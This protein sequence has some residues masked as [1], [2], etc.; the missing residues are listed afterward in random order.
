MQSVTSQNVEL[1]DA[2][3]AL[4]T[5]QIIQNAVMFGIL[6]ALGLFFANR[7][8]LGAPILEARLRG[9]IGCG[10][11]SAQYL[12]LS[13]IIGVVASLLIIGLDTCHLPACPAS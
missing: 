3:A 4:L 9:E 10:S 7:I 5:I 13:I 12:P 1:A 6:T 11:E 2:I 8:G